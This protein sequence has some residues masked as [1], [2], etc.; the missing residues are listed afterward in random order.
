MTVQNDIN[1]FSTAGKDFRPLKICLLGYRSKPHCGGQ[2]VYIKYLSSALAKLGHQVDVISGEP[3]PELTA[4]VNLIKMPGLNLFEKEH[5][6]RA[7]RPKNLLSY[8]DIY[9]WVSVVSGGFPEMYTF[10]RR[11]V[12]YFKERNSNYDLIHDNQSLCY[13]LL[14]LQQ[15]NIPVVVTVHHPITKDLELALNSS[16]YWF[17][18]LLIKRWHSFLRMQKRVVPLLDHLLTVSD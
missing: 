8:T 9:E 10:G 4:N 15:M 18:R 11:I 14:E 3:Y 16:T 6:F 17:N 1:A 7:L 5:R 13:G 12:R 2:G